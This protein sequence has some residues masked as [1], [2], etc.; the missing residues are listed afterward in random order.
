MND[1]KLKPCAVRIRFQGKRN[2]EGTSFFVSPT[3]TL[4]SCLIY[5]IDL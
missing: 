1:E 5:L 4:I 3:L 2:D